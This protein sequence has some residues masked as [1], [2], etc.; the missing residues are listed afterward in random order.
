[1][2]TETLKVTGMTCGGCASKVTNAL[3]SVTG[4][5]DVDLS[6]SEGLAR[7]QFNEHQTSPAAGRC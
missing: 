4:V 6:L 7:V 5:S 2:Q 1:M 3:K